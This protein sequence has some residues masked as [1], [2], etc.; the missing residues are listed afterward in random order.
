[1]SRV[2][3]SSSCRP[4]RTSSMEQFAGRRGPRPDIRR[5]DGC[6][7]GLLPVAHPHLVARDGLVTGWEACSRWTA[8]FQRFGTS[9]APRRLLT[10]SMVRS[11]LFVERE[12]ST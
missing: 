3:C 9:S 11:P 5:A 1:M 12:P 4:V 8:V 7:A 6:T 2:L 10:V